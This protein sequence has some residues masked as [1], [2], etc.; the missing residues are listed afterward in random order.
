MTNL[1]LENK[2]KT[3]MN[4]RYWSWRIGKAAGKAEKL[5]REDQFWICG[6]GQ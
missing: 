2:E 1:D 4:S 6:F 3:K 5:G